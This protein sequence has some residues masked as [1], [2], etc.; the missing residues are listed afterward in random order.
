MRDAL[1]RL[2]AFVRIAMWYEN[3]LDFLECIDSDWDR[4]TKDLEAA[5][6]F[7]KKAMRE[8]DI[9]R[10]CIKWMS[11]QERLTWEYTRDVEEKEKNMDYDE[12]SQWDWFNQKEQDKFYEHFIEPFFEEHP[13]LNPDDDDVFEVVEGTLRDEMYA[14]DKYECIIL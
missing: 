11:K 13:E 4:G 12:L 10:T 8:D 1:D 14:Q 3:F 7:L 9:M 2:D 5:K 6:K